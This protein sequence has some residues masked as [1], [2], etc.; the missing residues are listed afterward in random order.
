MT[1]TPSKSRTLLLTFLMVCGSSQASEWVSLGKDS[2]G[3]R[4]SFIDASTIEIYGDLR[5]AS[6]KTVIAPRVEQGIGSHSSTWVISATQRLAFRCME[7]MLRDEALV[8]HFED[9]SD[10]AARASEYPS[11]WRAF[12]PDTQ[13]GRMADFI[14]S[15]RAQ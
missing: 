5:R 9:G 11:P 15:W 8:L 13:E 14:C 2:S 10:E 3:K 1:L 4:T 12:A 6:F 7:E